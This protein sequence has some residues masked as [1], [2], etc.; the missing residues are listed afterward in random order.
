MRQIRLALPVAQATTLVTVDT[1][2][3][4]LGVDAETVT[5][6]C[7]SG[8]LVAFELQTATAARREIRIWVDSIRGH[9]D[10][11]RAA[12]DPAEE[13]EAIIGHTAAE[14]IACTQVAQRFCVHRRS[15]YRWTDEGDLD[16]H[17]VGRVLQVRRSSLVPFLN[18]RRIR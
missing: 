9:I 14:W 7:E 12:A 16:A 11:I 10:G 3:A 5:G 17:L 2:R 1:A 8:Q 4:A 15:V 6:L 18:G 13:I